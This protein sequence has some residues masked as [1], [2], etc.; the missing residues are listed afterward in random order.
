[1]SFI[2]YKEIG[3]TS[4]YNSN[5]FGP[6]D[7][8]SAIDLSRI[9]STSFFQTNPVHVLCMWIVV[10]Q[11]T[12]I[13]NAYKHNFTI[14]HDGENYRF[15]GEIYSISCPIQVSTDNDW[16]DFE[17]GTEGVNPTFSGDEMTIVGFIRSPN[18][19]DLKI[20]SYI[21]IYGKQS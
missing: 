9:G 5:T 10:D 21:E 6:V 7:L 12:A 18:S 14:F 1:M 13:G 20:T 8:S 11:V 17:L 19:I 4:I 16:G 3:P 15:V 2:R